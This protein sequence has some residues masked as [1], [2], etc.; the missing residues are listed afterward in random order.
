M[1]HLSKNQQRLRTLQGSIVAFY[2]V[3][4]V[5]FFYLSVGKSLVFTNQILGLVFL[6]LTTDTFLLVV[7]FFRSPGHHGKLSFDS[8]KL[9]II[10]TA[11][12]SEDVI[13]ET[14]SNAL[15]HVPAER[16]FV[17]CDLTPDKEIQEN[18]AAIAS[19]MGVRVFK[20]ARNLNKALGISNAIKHVDTPY[21]LTIDDDTYIGKV[22]IPTSLL[23]D[24]FS[25]VAFNV[26]PKET[27]RI[28]TKFQTFE[29]RKSMFL[30]KH[31]RSSVGAIGNVS[32]AI[33]LFHTDDL[34]RQSSLHSGQFGGEDQ[35]RTLLV[36]L[37][38]ERKGVVFMDSLVPTDA[39]ATWKA[40]FRQRAY[41]WNFATHELFALS[42]KA[43]FSK[44]TH[45]LLKA[46]RAYNLFI[47]LTEPLRVFLWLV[48]F[49]RPFAT[50]VLLLFFVL[51]SLLSWFK[52]GRKDP[53][54]V[55]LLFPLYSK[56]NSLG[57]F[58]GHFW[59]FP[60]KYEYIF[61]K[62]LH[63]LISGRKLLLEYSLVAILL[64]A[65][66]PLAGVR[67]YE[68]KGKYVI[69]SLFSSKDDGVSIQE[70]TMAPFSP[71]GNMVG[72]A[73]TVSE[74]STNISPSYAGSGFY[75]V[76]ATQ[77]DG[78]IHVARKAINQYVAETKSTPL[79]NREQ[80]RAEYSLIKT[81]QV[82]Q[83]TQTRRVKVGGLY[84][85]SKEEIEKVLTT[86]R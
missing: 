80:S 23:D 18:V 30:G 17:V 43:I 7:H 4:M 47:L 6:S 26:M 76:F 60:T 40:L 42:W 64:L 85:I 34:V 2:V 56:F 51:M 79:S 53:L 5:V 20:N 39:P 62:K 73:E 48:M 84:R 52:T 27:G 21:V 33:G 16:I 74:T 59:W 9:T 41:M 83:S 38:S 24:G 35:Q 71:R 29:Y 49:T 77:G 22:F 10:I 55:V 15:S 81:A 68:A 78:Q 14:I 72:D 1:K 8:S 65:L 13:A 69:G 12:K 82:F 31:L 61:K 25:A 32:G 63:K 44:K 86:P 58:V 75:I 45:W 3:V 28:V 19:R 66:W 11:Y 57:R 50:L 54:W 37:E 36:H 46:E 67:F 70:A